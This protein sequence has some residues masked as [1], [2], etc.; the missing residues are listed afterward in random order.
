[1]KKNKLIDNFKSATNGLLSL[2]ANLFSAP[3]GVVVFVTPARRYF[4][5]R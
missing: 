5:R 2:V 3:V 1:M 4:L